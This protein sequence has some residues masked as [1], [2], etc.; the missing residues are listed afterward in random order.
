MKRLFDIFFSS[1]FL[2]I[3]LP[4]FVFAI[5]GILL[6]SPG[7]IFYKAQRVGK[8]R[9]S[10]SMLK[11]R[12]MRV[13]N[14]GPVITSGNDDRI[15]RF[16][17]F[18]RKTKI[19]EFPQFLNVL[20]GDMS[21]VGPRPEDPKIVA[22]GYTP[23]MMKTLDVKPG[24]TSSGALFYYAYSE[25]LLDENDPEKS[26]IETLLPRKLATELGYIKRASFLNDIGIILL[27]ALTIF[28]VITGLKP[29]LP[30]QDIEFADTFLKNENGKL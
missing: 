20:R 21:I 28:G 2:L 27:T 25:D 29:E 4:F 23:W 1:F 18:L 7:P 11:F 12:S 22:D 14:Y 5:V 16:G 26:Y 19:D 30:R 3:A 10:F 13:S 8:G 17:A 9:K 6:T 15:F 24:I